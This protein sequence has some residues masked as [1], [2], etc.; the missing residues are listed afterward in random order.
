MKDICAELVSSS[1][2]DK[3]SRRTTTCF[4]AVLVLS[5]L[6]KEDIASA[7]FFSSQL[8]LNSYSPFRREKGRSEKKNSFFVHTIMMKTR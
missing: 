1:F 4:L 8:S 6:K 5:A 7:Q 3:T 2:R